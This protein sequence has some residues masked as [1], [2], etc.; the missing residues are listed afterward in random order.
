MGGAG[1]GGWVGRVEVAAEWFCSGFGSGEGLGLFSLGNGGVVVGVRLGLRWGWVFG[2]GSTRASRR[3][4]LE[5]V[6]EVIMAEPLRY[7][8]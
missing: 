2:W 7:W 6:S 4:S 1:V 3:T 5:I 8:K